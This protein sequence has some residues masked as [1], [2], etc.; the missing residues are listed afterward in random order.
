[1]PTPYKKL[2]LSAWVREGKAA[3]CWKAQRAFISI[4]TP[5]S[6]L[7]APQAWSHGVAKQERTGIDCPGQYTAEKE[8]SLR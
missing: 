3:R 1:M 6:Y 5:H 7:D 8:A 2:L 4:G